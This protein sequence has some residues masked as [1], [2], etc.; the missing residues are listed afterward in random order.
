M[1][2]IYIYIYIDTYEASVDRL[3]NRCPIPCPFPSGPIRGRFLCAHG[4]HHLHPHTATNQ[5]HMS[6]APFFGNPKCSSP[7]R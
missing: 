1:L 6:L 7:C 3:S 4:Y 5:T 2:Y